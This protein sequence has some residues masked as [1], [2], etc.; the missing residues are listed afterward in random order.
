M[1]TAQPQT[2]KE[3]CF[4]AT[5]DN[6]THLCHRKYAHVSHKGLEMLQSKEMVTGLPKMSNTVVMCTDCV[7]GKQHHD[8]IPK[9]SQWRATLKL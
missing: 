6:V 3:P 8:L 5:A 7:K 4:N 1:L 9:K 2:K